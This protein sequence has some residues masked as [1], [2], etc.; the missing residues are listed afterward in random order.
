MLSSK[1]LKEKFSFIPDKY[2]DT[3]YLDNL[4]K[5]RFDESNP[6]FYHAKGFNKFGYQGKDIDI[7]VIETKS[8]DFALSSIKLLSNDQRTSGKGL[9]VVAIGANPRGTSGRSN[10]SNKERREANKKNPRLERTRGNLLRRIIYTMNGQN[11][12]STNRVF[13]KEFI[14]LD[15]FTL[16]TKDAGDLIPLIRDSSISTK[17]K[18]N[19]AIINYWASKA[20]W[21]IPCWGKD[22]DKALLKLK[23]YNDFI[24]NDIIKE[25]ERSTK[26]SVYYYDMNNDGSPTQSSTPLHYE[27]LKQFK[28]FY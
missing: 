2:L 8:N 17:K 28:D 1:E 3:D 4:F 6:N 26:A 27:N 9:T 21:L 22:P 24:R 10:Y 16:R 25:I 18:Y 7:K 12:D 14:Q 15:L 11:A 5:D 13:L 23:N 20:D 19:P